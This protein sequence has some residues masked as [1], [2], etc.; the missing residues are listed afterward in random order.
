MGS[1]SRAAALD[2][3]VMRVGGRDLPLLMGTMKLTLLLAAR[4]SV[5]LIGSAMWPSYVLYDGV[6]ITFASISC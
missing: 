2:M 5:G 3:V 4:K 1:T 6:V